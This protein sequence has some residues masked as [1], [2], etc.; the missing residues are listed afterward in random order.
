MPEMTREQAVEIARTV[1]VGV[2]GGRSGY[3][4]RA[5]EAVA[6]LVMCIDREARLET[7]REIAFAQCLGCIKQ[8]PYD[9][10]DGFH[11]MPMDGLPSQR[12][13]ARVIRFHYP[14]AFTEEPQS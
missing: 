5:Q 4:E 8:D 3:W 14:A 6:H 7:A 9:P 12:C 1:L 11:Y 2:P 13:N 10:D